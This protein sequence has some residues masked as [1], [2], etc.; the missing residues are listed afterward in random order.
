MQRFFSAVLQNFATQS[1]LMAVGV[2]ARKALAASAAINWMLKDGMNRLVRMGV[3]TQFG[4]SFDSDLKVRLDGGLQISEIINYWLVRPR[5]HDPKARLDGGPEI[6]NC[7]LI[8]PRLHAASS[9]L[10]ASLHVQLACPHLYNFRTHLKM[11]RILLFEP[12]LLPTLHCNVILDCQPCTLSTQHSALPFGVYG[13]CLLL[14]RFRFTTSLL[15]TACVSCEFLTPRFPSH[16]LLLTAVSNVGRAVGLTTFVS[17]Q[18]AFQQ[19]LCASGNMADL[20]SK[21]QVWQTGKAPASL[22]SV[23]RNLQIDSAIAQLRR[24][25]V[26]VAGSLS[27]STQL[28]EIPS[29][30]GS[31]RSC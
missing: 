12:T 5:L 19:A 11:H 23:C 27:A 13:L 31:C 10:Q 6:I 25:G 3:A 8:G 1:L 28:P 2:G 16:F 26:L 21:T 4:D 22:T 7:W 29:N 9:W 15:Y 17:T 14:Q 18:P 24:A 30:L 20:A